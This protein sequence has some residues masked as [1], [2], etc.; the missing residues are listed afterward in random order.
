MMLLTVVD[1]ACWPQMAI[2]ADE[3]V[4]DRWSKIARN[5]VHL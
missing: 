2:V 1:S 4:R 3:K 5:H